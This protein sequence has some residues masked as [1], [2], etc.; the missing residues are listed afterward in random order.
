MQELV[1]LDSQ[2]DSS[3]NY[4]MKNN[5]FVLWEARFVQRCPEYIIVYLSS[6]TG[7]KMGCQMCHL[8]ASGQTLAY[9]LEK[10]D[11]MEQVYTVLD[12]V[13][14][15]AKKVH[16][17]FMARGEPLANE[18]VNG[19]LLR[20]LGIEARDKGLIP[21]YLI[22]TIFPKGFTGTLE[23]RFTSWT[24]DIYYSLYST[25][26]VFRKKWLPGAMDC[27]EALQLLGQWQDA[28]NKIPCIHYPLIAGENDNNWDAEL[29]VGAVK[30]IGLRVNF[31]IIRYNPYDSDSCES[32]RM[33]DYIRI[34]RQE[35]PVK[36]VDRVG[37]DGLMCAVGA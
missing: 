36:V 3:I 16:F 12:R 6:Q 4:V 25:D 32:E 10:K 11:F 37:M 2:E 19:N 28:T 22:S 17:N 20:R 9:D 7:C 24:P 33:V 8:T 15:N 29:V 14:T 23:D 18:N 26:S 5:G 13:R 35:F 31:N 27:F 30:R 21:K 1:R 34:I